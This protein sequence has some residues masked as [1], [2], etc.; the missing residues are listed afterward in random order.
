MSLLTMWPLSFL[1]NGPGY[2][3]LD[4]QT[5]STII[6][7][8]APDRLRGFISGVQGTLTDGTSNVYAGANILEMYQL[9]TDNTVHFKVAGLV[10]NSGWTQ[11]MVDDPSNIFTRVGATYLQTG[12]NTQ[13]TWFNANPFGANGSNHDIYFD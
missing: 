9:E 13:W 10:A 5:L 1:S 12:G 4:R 6:T 3:S 2:G 7:G 8:S 11:F